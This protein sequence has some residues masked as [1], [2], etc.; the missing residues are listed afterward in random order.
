MSV[1]ALT[2]SIRELSEVIG[3][4]QGEVA[5]IR[6][7]V[8]AMRE[9]MDELVFQGREWWSARNEEWNGFEEE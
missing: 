9:G 1:F 3:K 2:D 8:T 4:L 5:E 6:D 7:K